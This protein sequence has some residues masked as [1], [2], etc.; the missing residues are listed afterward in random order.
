MIDPVGGCPWQV[1]CQKLAYLQDCI[2]IENH[3][4][5]TIKIHRL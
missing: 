5:P 2:N 4:L 3:N 1:F